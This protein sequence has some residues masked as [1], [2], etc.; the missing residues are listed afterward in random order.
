M[1]TWPLDLILFN[2]SQNPNSPDPLRSLVAAV[3][4]QPASHYQ[5]QWVLT[6]PVSRAEIKQITMSF[7][8]TNQG[9]QAKHIS[10][11]VHSLQV[12]ILP[13]DIAKRRSW[14]CTIANNL[15]GSTMLQYRTVIK[16]LFSGWMWACVGNT[17]RQHLCMNHEW[18][19]VVCVDRFMYLCMLACLC[20]CMYVYFVHFVCVHLW[21]CMCVCERVC[22]HLWRHVCVGA[23]LCVR[24]CYLSGHNKCL[25]VGVAV[26]VCVYV[27][28][29][30]CVRTHMSVCVCV[31]VRRSFCCWATGGAVA[32][33][34]MS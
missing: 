2:G 27:Y 33:G 25:V 19:V 9:K 31:C 16:Q 10:I 18:E 8:L 34:Q 3:Q 7:S 12:R 6:S 17:S 21:A 30:I 4:F 26:Y 28:V 20:V 24:A 5:C 11:L 1:Y 32:R 13:W 15:H 23:C 29:Y 14:K 22:A